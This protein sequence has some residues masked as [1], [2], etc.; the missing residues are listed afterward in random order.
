MA[1]DTIAVKPVDERLLPMER[2]GVN[3]LRRHIDRPMLVPNTAYY[4]RA[5]LRGDIQRAQPIEL[6]P[7]TGG[8]A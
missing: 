7:P 1:D 3:H 4:R 2:S 5:L 8:D 6:L